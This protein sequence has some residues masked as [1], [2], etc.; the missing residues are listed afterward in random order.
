MLRT[1]IITVFCGPWYVLMAVLVAVGVFLFAVWL[2]NISLITSVITSDA[3]TFMQKISF[4]FSLLGSIT[5]NFTVISATSIILIAILFGANVALLT[6]YM[7]KTRGTGGIRTIG[8]LGVTG[9]VSGFLGIGCV[10]CGTFVLSSI[11]I[12]MGV[13]GLL[14]YLPFGGEEFGFIAIGLLLYSLHA[15]S[16]KITTPNVC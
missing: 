11:L 4:M 7:K 10:A 12:L 5:T 8:G 15:I 6:Y 3:G 1:Q 13:G 16:R 14:A 9:L 2:P